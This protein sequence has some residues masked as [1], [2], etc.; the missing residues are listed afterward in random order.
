MNT[1]IINI[2]YADANNYKSGYFLALAGEFTNAHYEM[3]VNG[4][5]EGCFVVPN[6]I[7]N[8]LE[9]AGHDMLK[10]HGY[11]PEADHGWSAIDELRNTDSYDAFI[12]RISSNK[13]AAIEDAAVC[14]THMD[15]DTFVSLAIQSQNVE[16]ED[17]RIQRKY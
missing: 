6:Q 15:I 11:D 4:L 1:S 9:H 5:D 12:A 10:K 17:E 16:D 13:T 3:L 7:D 14:F 8:E 2:S